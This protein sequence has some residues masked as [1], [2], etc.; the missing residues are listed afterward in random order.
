MAN[1]A[2]TFIT[3]TPVNDV[4]VLQQTLREFAAAGQI[5]TGPQQLANLALRARSPVMMQALLTMTPPTPTPAQTQLEAAIRA[6]DLAGVQAAIQAGANPRTNYDTPFYIAAQN[7]K[8]ILMYLLDTA[9]SLPVDTVVSTEAVAIYIMSAV[10]PVS[11]LPTSRPETL[12]ALVRDY[13]VPVDVADNM[14]LR[15]LIRTRSPTGRV[16]LPSIITLLQLGAYPR[17]NTGKISE[18]WA[19]VGRSLNAGCA[20]GAPAENGTYLVR[21]MR[22]AEIVTV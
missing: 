6:G 5:K 2:V 9:F 19:E 11:E 15:F 21:V 12:K 3:S 20:Q 22:A 1:P 4:A 10:A 13:Q 7:Q 18:L 17:G 16:D 8:Q 14:A